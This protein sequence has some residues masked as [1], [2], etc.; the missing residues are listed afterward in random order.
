MTWRR[1]RRK[2]KRKDLW[3]RVEGISSNQQAEII[4]IKSHLLSSVVL[5]DEITR[6]TL[7]GLPLHISFSQETS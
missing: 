7:K 2:E 3:K 4:I 1:R 5:I 6:E